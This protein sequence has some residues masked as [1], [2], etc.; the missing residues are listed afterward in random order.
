MSSNKDNN[1]FSELNKRIEE[2]GLKESPNISLTEIEELYMRH[3]YKFINYLESIEAL[4]Y[5]EFQ[6]ERL[7]YFNH[8]ITKGMNP[9]IGCFPC[10]SREHILENEKSVI[11][12]LKEIGRSYVLFNAANNSFRQLGELV[13]SNKCSTL[14]AAD[15]SIENLLLH[16]D[17]VLVITEFSKLKSKKDK[18]LLLR[19]IINIISYAHFQDIY[20]SSDLVLI[21]YADFIQKSWLRIGHYVTIIPP[22]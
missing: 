4:K 13:G 8:E 10:F 21:D 22:K 16:S 15:K 18:A 12:A 11:Q 6:L 17:S 19:S 3:R 2:L 5:Y 7:F 9:K 14:Q 20:H 1:F